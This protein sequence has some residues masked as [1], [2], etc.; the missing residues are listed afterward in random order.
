MLHGRAWGMFWGIGAPSHTTR[1]ACMRIW[2]KFCATTASGVHC[3]PGIWQLR[4]AGYG[5]R[6]G[7][8]RAY[9]QATAPWATHNAP[10][11][12]QRTRARAPAHLQQRTCGTQRHCHLASATPTR[13]QQPGAHLQLA[14]PG[15][16]AAPPACAA[17]KAKPR[18]PRGIW[19]SCRAAPTLTLT[20]TQIGWRPCSA[21]APM[22]LQLAPASGVMW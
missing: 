22:P 11:P 3:A 5:S 15:I 17:G 7:N 1:L 13:T 9:S 18:P 4:N 12:E 10:T 8:S 20:Q 21:A 2:F 16:P 14:G 6:H 19:P